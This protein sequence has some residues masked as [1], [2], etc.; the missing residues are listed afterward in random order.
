[1]TYN[2]QTI[3]EG[4]KLRL[5][6]L[7]LFAKIHP[8]IK[9]KVSNLCQKTARYHVPKKLFQ[10]RTSRQN[11]VLFP[12]K[13]IYKNGITID[14]I[15]TFEGGVCVEFVNKD[16]LNPDYQNIEVFKFFKDRIGG[17]SNFSSIVSF[18]S[19]FGDPGARIAR[20][21]FDEFNS[22][23]ESNQINFNK[24]II[25]RNPD[26]RWSGRGS[27]EHTIGNIFYEIKGGEQDG[28]ESH[29]KKQQ[30]Y[31]PACEYANEIVTN[32]ISLTLSY[33]ILHT[34]DIQDKLENNDMNLF[35]ELKKKI[36]NYLKHREYDEVDN[37]LNYCYSHD[38]LKY[39]K[40]I[41]YDTIEVEK[42]SIDQFSSECTDKSKRM[43]TAHNEAVD[44]QKYHFDET[45]DFLLSAAR[46]SNFFWLTHKSNMLM[47]DDTLHE[48]YKN[49]KERT[50]NRKNLFNNIT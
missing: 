26:I 15:K 37:L 44:K 38:S 33:F 13:H 29:T 9:T 19:E 10:D 23:I 17:N 31:N 47:Q 50:K 11:R 12:W 14:Q 27:N 45:N 36:S 46:P 35:N 3:S 32:D 5:S 22:M 2:N 18:R 16:Y 42:I 49:E 41:L 28:Y 40:N 4:N 39:T 43:V 30:I 21:S 48:Y 8:S 20:E 25:K 7:N 1:M 6:V 24:Q 34:Y